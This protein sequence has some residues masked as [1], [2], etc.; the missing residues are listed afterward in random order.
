MLSVTHAITNSA[1]PMMMAMT[2]LAAREAPT[3]ESAI[4]VEGPKKIRLCESKKERGEGTEREE[5][6]QRERELRET[7]RWKRQTGR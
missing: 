7:E 3:G 6:E 1:K 4:V 2:E 5:K